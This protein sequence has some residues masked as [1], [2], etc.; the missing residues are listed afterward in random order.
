MALPNQEMEDLEVEVSALTG[1]ITDHIL[2]HRI[3]NHRFYFF[4]FLFFFK[5]I[6]NF[7]YLY[8]LVL[9]TL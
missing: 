3:E 9:L 6:K 1:Q 4:Y 2:K 8:L 7:L 5:K